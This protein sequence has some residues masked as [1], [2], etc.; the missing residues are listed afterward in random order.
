MRRS[1]VSL[2]LSLLGAL[3]ATP[4]GAGPCSQEIAAYEQA[5]T[6]LPGITGHQSVHAQLHHQPTPDTLA[7]SRNRAAGDER[8]DRAALE[9]ARAADARGDRAACLEALSEA[10]RP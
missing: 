4:A 6:E 9:R 7:R 8:E 2:V 3:L 5:M 10:R 1:S